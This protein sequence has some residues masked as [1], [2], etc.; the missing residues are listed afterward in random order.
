MILEDKSQVW[1]D[2]HIFNDEDTFVV[3][4]VAE[5]IGSSS[6]NILKIN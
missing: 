3:S 6:F 1:E 4:A 5:S 2:L